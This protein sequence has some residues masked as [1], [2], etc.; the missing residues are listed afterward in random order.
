MTHDPSIALDHTEVERLILTLGAIG[1]HSGTG[2]W[3]RVY[4]PEWVAA[5]TLLARWMTEADMAVRSDAVGNLWGRI[6]GTEGGGVVAAGSHIDSQCPGG[7][8]DGALGVIAALVAVRAL[9]QAHGAPKRPVEVLSLCEEEG[10]R[11]A[12]AGFWGSRAITGHI[13]PG[14]ADTVLDAEGGSIA[15]AMRAV[16]LD[17]DQ[18]PMARRHDLAAFLELHIEQGPVLEDAG[19]PVAV[20]SA[21]TGIRH[22]QVTL[23]G[24]QN[25]AGA[26]PMDLRHDPMA[27]FAEL[28]G[29][30]IDHAHRL[31]RPAVT[32]V[33]RVAV[34]PNAPAIIPRDVTFTIDARHP[35]AAPYDAL[36]LTHQRLMAEV[37]ARR[38]LT[39]AV[40][41]QFDLKPTPCDP[42]LLQALTQ[43]AEAQ[44]VPHV[45]ITSGASHDSQQMAVICPVG[46]VFVRSVGGRSHTPE[47][48]STLSDILDGIRVLAGALYR[49]AW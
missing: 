7:R 12:T 40:E 31:G 47:E 49:L 25:H 45:T 42:A 33:G 15:D 6:E 26:Y 41:V 44:G 21:I 23:T 28:A 14:D 20:V 37:A 48:F 3:R 8:Y 11:F 16:G 24:E 36:H 39:L 10:S 1:A 35:I 9:V 29:Q 19:C 18:I 5:Q 38:G 13:A 2:V 22:T 46:M 32:T 17:P 30:L 27:G 4:D 34:W 43:S